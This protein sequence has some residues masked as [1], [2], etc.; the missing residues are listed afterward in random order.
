MTVDLRLEDDGWWALVFAAAAAVTAGVASAEADGPTLGAALAVSPAVVAYL[1]A[2]WFRSGATAIVAAAAVGSLILAAVVNETRAVPEGSLFFL[3]LSTLYVAFREHRIR[4]AVAV[5]V[6]TVP[7][8][9]LLTGTDLLHSAGWYYW[10]LGLLLAFVFGRIAHQARLLIVDLE[11]TRNQITLQA[12]NDERR[13]IATDVH[14]LVGHSLSAVLMHVGGARRLVRTD[15]A[16]AESIL[17]DAETAIRQN[18][19]DIRRT[20]SLLHDG[21]QEPGPAP[22]LGDIEPLVEQYRRGGLEISTQMPYPSFEPDPT[23]GL[24]AYRIIAEALANVSKHTSGTSVVLTLNVRTTTCELQVVNSGGVLT[25]KGA[26]A[27]IGLTAMTERANSVGGSLVAGP[28]PGGW[29]VEARLPI[30]PGPARPDEA[31]TGSTP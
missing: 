3:I 13:R 29:K 2:R 12:V 26:G 15:A 9:R 22:S 5:L 30:A 19:A 11:R 27:G 6:V 16:E 14:D 7:I 20:V 1:L 10:T 4:H 24:A 18:M 25:N 28:Y 21:T 8:P 31:F 23:V 17:T